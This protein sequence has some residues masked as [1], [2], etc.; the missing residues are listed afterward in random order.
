M[1]R[2]QKPVHSVNTSSKT[3]F[4]RPGRDAGVRESWRCQ[5]DLSCVPQ[6]LS[7]SATLLLGVPA[8]HRL[9]RP[10]PQCVHPMLLVGHLAN[11]PQQLQLAFPRYIPIHRTYFSKLLRVLLNH[12]QFCAL[13]RRCPQSNRIRHGPSRGP[14]PRG[15]DKRRHLFLCCELL[16]QWA[17]FCRPNQ[18][19]TLELYELHPDSVEGVWI[20]HL[21]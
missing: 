4:L 2:C 17:T 6:P 16:I 7:V 13:S 10:R 19:P 3:S 18:R 12:P 21:D 11:E 20:T 9:V 14:L 1:T 8:E 15:H 5:D